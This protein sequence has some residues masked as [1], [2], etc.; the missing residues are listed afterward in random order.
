MLLVIGFEVI[1]AHHRHKVDAP[2]GTALLL[3]EAAASA[4]GKDLASCGVFSRHGH[5]GPRKTGCIGF[6]TIR[7]GEIAGEHTVMFVGDIGIMNYVKYQ[8]S[9][10]C[11][12]SRFFAG[13]N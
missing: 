2:S 10:I 11:C 4:Q 3:G 1:E 9:G 12:E 6:S 13:I 5:T 7:G 8:E